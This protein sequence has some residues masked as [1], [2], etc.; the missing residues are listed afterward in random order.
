M[1]NRFLLLAVWALLPAAM[2]LASE[3]TFAVIE[4][5][6]DPDPLF[7]EDALLEVTFT[8][9]FRALSRDRADEPERRP[10]TLSWTDADGEQALPVEFEPRGKSRRDRNVCTF[11][12]LWVH[13]EKDTV[14]GTLFKK[15]NKVK[16][17]TYCR[18]PA[19]FQDYVVKE[20]LVYRIF[21]ELSDASFRV[22]LARIHYQEAGSDKKP[23][24][25]YGF[26]IEHKK[27]LGKRLDLKIVDPA[28]RIPIASLVPEQAAIAE[29]FQFM[30]SNTDF[31]FIAPPAEDTCC[32]NA[33]LFDAEGDA[34]DG[35]GASRHLVVPY[36]FDRTGFVSP[37][38]GAPAENLGQRTFRDRV[39]RGFCRSPEYLA[40]AIE[41]T[42]AARPAI[43]ALVREQ[44]E[45]SPRS[46]DRALAY[47]ASYYEILERPRDLERQL[48]CRP[49]K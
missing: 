47:L 24:T 2:L 34:V 10:G 26:F 5:V 15:Q 42:Q 21:N 28:E 41:Q 45:L 25:R 38:N 3:R 20:Y 14:K 49:V 29:L 23:I 30:V 7:A 13:F 8:A 39:Y 11:P 31:S 40:A 27:R 46:R 6:R 43:E 17:V 12:P 35:V 18:S 33:V 4:T 16:V 48:K 37:P 36:D 32:H 1:G 44:A 19:N 9:P 22:R